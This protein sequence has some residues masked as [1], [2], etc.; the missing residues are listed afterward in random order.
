M[1]TQIITIPVTTDLDPS[2]LL[3]IALEL[4]EQLSDTVESYGAEATVD[5]AEVSVESSD[6]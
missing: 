2:Q 5:E 4:A 1:E 3:D 6:D